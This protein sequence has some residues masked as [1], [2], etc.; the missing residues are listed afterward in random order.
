M[1][2][3]SHDVASFSLVVSILGALA[4]VIAGYGLDRIVNGRRLLAILASVFAVAVIIAFRTSLA[5]ISPSLRI[6]K[7]WF[8]RFALPLA[9]DL[10]LHHHRRP[11]WTRPLR[12]FPGFLRRSD[13]LCVGSTGS[14]Q[15][16]DAYDPPLSRTS[17][18]QRRILRL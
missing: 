7:D 12:T 14:R 17:R 13:W 15:H 10:P 9:G 8:K 11:R 2:T 6:G 16:G 18:N 3:G 1:K 4:G 5:R